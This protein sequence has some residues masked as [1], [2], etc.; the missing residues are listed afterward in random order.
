MP[1]ARA[2]QCLQSKDTTPADVYLYWLA[3]VAQLNDL[4]RRDNK[5]TPS[6]KSKYEETLKDLIRQIA[7]YRFSQLIEDERASNVYFSICTRSWFVLTSR[8]VSID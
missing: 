1:L 4:I 6:K 7:N 2:I 8:R 3:V 5:P